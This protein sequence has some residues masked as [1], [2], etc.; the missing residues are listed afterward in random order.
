MTARKP[1]LALAGFLALG[2][3]VACSD[4]SGSSSG[5]GNGSSSNGSYSESIVID[6]DTVR[7][8]AELTLKL[9]SHDA[10]AHE[11]AVGALHKNYCV[12]DGESVSWQDVLESPDST[13]MSY[14]FAKIPAAALADLENNGYVV[15]DGIALIVRDDEGDDYVYVGRDSSTVFGEWQ[16][17][18]CWT[19]RDDEIVC[20]EDPYAGSVLKIS[21]GSVTEKE[22]FLL[23][24]ANYAY[25]DPF[26]TFFPIL[27]YGQLADTSREYAIPAI[28][29]FYEDSAGVADAIDDLGIEITEQKEKS[30]SFVLNGKS[31]TIR[32]LKR[33]WSFRGSDLEY[34]S[35]V[36]VVGESE[37]CRITARSISGVDKGYCSDKYMANYDWDYEEDYDENEFEYANG[38]SWN[39]DDEYLPCL[40]RLAGAPAPAAALAK[41]VRWNAAAKKAPVRRAKGLLIR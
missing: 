8:T 3:L 14:R 5:G 30:Q 10:E 31:Y 7:Y 15:K 18:S 21:K 16:T 23:N 4:S 24:K 6:G 33:D 37:T 38:I 28:A 19:N 35:D 39:N 20:D 36:E 34:S 1:L 32:I 17:T 29:I 40:E 12:R 41:A 25:D 11:F 26:G 27:V 22:T 13:L 2:A 9:L